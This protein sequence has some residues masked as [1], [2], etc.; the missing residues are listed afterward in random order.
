[1]GKLKKIVCGAS[2]AAQ[3][4]GKFELKDPVGESLAR[5]SCRPLFYKT[6]LARHKYLRRPHPTGASFLRLRQAWESSSGLR[7]HSALM[8][9]I[10]IIT[11]HGCGVL[12]PILR[13]GAD[14]LGYHSAWVRSMSNEVIALY[15]SF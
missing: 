13:M 10:D 11:P 15:C 5:W 3:V 9:I 4:G 7:R 1:M 12:H 6:L 2:W 14:C 8:R